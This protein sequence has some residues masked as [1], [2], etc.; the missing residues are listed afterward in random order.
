MFVKHLDSK[1]L[2]HYFQQVRNSTEINNNT[3]MLMMKHMLAHSF[4]DP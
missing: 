1:V 4:G 2:K 3:C